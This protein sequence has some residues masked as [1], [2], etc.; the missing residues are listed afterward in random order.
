MRIA[1]AMSGGL[2]SSFTAVLLKE[3]GHDVVGITAKILLC[4]DMDGTQPRYDVCCSPENIRD[5]A[6]IARQYGFP[7]TVLDVESDFSR[8]VIEPFCTEYLKGRTPSPCIL[9]NSRIKFKKLIELSKSM[10]CE[11]LATGHYARLQQTQSGRYYISMGTDADKDQ[12]YFLFMLSQDI[13]KDVLFPLG[14][15]RKSEIREMAVKHKLSVAHKPESQE[16]CFVMDNDYPRYIERKTGII[17]HWGDII[18]SK[19][20]IIG[21]HHGIHRYT[22]GQRRGLGISSE[23]PLYV[24]EID[25]VKNVIIAGP[26][27]ALLRKGL[28]AKDISYMKETSLNNQEAY[29]KTRSM[30]KPVK[31]RLEEKDG[32][33]FVY[34]DQPQSG[35]TPGQASVFYTKNGDIM[36]GAWIEY[37]I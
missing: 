5:A 26:K 11:K 27:E 35:I 18:D 36:G 19:G 13:L 10:G 28:F 15:Y 4:A 9:C 30:Q 37:S 21:A 24:I 17:P 34:F 29:I 16:I 23:R 1:V 12:S 33:I 32:G 3:M 7:H 22:I 2:D 14:D 20:N 25:P 6:N 31:G 8:E